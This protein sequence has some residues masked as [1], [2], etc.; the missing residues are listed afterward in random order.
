MAQREN[1]SAKIRNHIDSALIKKKI[2]FSSYL[3]QIQNGA[4]AKSYMTNGLLI[5]V[6]GEMFAHFLIY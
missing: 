5:H 2:W 3:R 6:Y 1:G 4:V